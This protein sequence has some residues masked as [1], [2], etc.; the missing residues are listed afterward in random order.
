ML[1]YNAKQLAGFPVSGMLSRSGLTFNVSSIAN[2]SHF[3]GI[4]T[5]GVNIK[6]AIL[7]K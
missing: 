3:S 5:V 7:S 4:V 6:P 2:L 1:I